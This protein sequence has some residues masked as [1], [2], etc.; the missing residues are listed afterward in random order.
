MSDEVLS[1]PFPRPNFKIHRL[2]S[3]LSELRQWIVQNRFWANEAY[4]AFGGDGDL[5]PLEEHIPPIPDTHMYVSR[6]SLCDMYQ[7]YCY[8]RRLREGWDT[9]LRDW[10]EEWESKTAVKHRLSL[11][12]AGVS[13]LANAFVDPE[14][15]EAHLESFNKRARKFQE[16]ILKKLGVY[17]DLKGRGGDIVMGGAP[18]EFAIGVDMGSPDQQEEI[19]FDKLFHGDDEEDDSP[20]SP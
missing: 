19:D 11:V 2:L 3:H 13:I 17:D 4:A 10:E 12:H 9:M 7:T 5:V 8:M 16:A 18:D 15:R 1:P 6:I 20:P 14:T